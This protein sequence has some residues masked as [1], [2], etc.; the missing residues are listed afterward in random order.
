MTLWEEWHVGA[1]SR[2]VCEYFFP[3]NEGANN[4][5]RLKLPVVQSV[6]MYIYVSIS[7]YAKHFYMY[8]LLH[9]FSFVTWIS[10]LYPHWVI[11]QIIYKVATESLE[12]PTPSSVTCPCVYFII[13][14]S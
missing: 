5:K 9:T 8:C 14:A 1:G 2:W 3:E 4:V 10:L 6:Y 11:W 12:L 13:M 7:M